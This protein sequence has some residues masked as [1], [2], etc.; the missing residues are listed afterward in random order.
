M[1]TQLE[2]ATARITAYW[3]FVDKNGGDSPDEEPMLV[4]VFWNKKKNEWT[5]YLEIEEVVPGLDKQGKT[6]I[7][8]IHFTAI[9]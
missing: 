1:A 6:Y 8:V 3:T 7:E 4:I 2:G 9:R 5:K